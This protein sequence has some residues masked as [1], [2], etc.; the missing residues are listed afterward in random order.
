MTDQPNEQPVVFTYFPSKI[1]VYQRL[2]R[3][4][5]YIK[6]T[7][8]NSPAYLTS[9]HSTRV[10][11]TLATT[12]GNNEIITFYYNDPIFPLKY[13]NMLPNILCFWIHLECPLNIASRNVRLNLSPP[14]RNVLSVLTSCSAA[15]KA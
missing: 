1:N 2:Y 11:L 13:H 8:Y 4:F 9:L 12:F 15:A 10:T 5:E 3:L 7:K 14:S 6:S